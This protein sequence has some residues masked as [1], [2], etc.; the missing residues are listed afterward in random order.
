M[1]DIYDMQLAQKGIEIQRKRKNAIFQFNEIF[2]KL[3]E[4]VSGIE[5][6]QIKYC[7]SWKKKSAEQNIV[8]SIDEVVQFLNEKRDQDKIMS[9]TLSGPHR[10]KII[11]E[12]NGNQFINTASTGQ[13]RLISL[14]LRVCQAIYY[15]R[16][17]RI[18]PVLL[19]DDVMLELDPEKRQK[20]TEFLPEYD[21]L[22]CTFLPGEPY[23]RYK[24]DTTRIYSLKSGEWNEL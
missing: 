11:F 10:D 4:S 20:F 1:L 23:E 12:K 9:T 18:K 8:P 16:I 5:G 7:P 21:Q 3:Y 17:T 19:M 15:N 13:C 6:L 24:K 22:F 14:V 2:G